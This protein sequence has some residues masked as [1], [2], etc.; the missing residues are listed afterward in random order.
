[1]MQNWKCGSYVKYGLFCGILLNIKLVNKN[2][3]IPLFDVI[4][5]VNIRHK[6]DHSLEG[7]ITVLLENRKCNKDW[8]SVENVY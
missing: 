2:V 3:Y 8:K 5:V 4:S 7:I 6:K 1:M